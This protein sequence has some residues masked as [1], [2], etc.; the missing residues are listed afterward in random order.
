MQGHAARE[1][2]KNDRHSVVQVARYNYEPFVSQHEVIL[3]V[4]MV[5]LESGDCHVHVAGM[6]VSGIAY[7]GLNHD[8]WILLSLG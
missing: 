4:V 1:E 6:V 7:Q 2:W 8:L 3:V 5:I